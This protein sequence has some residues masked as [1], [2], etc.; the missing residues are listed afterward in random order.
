MTE[1][2]ISF[3][4]IARTLEPV[5]GGKDI[6]ITFQ[7]SRAIISA[8]VKPKRQLKSKGICHV[9]ANPALIK[10]EKEAFAMAMV[11]KYGKNINS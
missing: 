5:F 10:H 3:N 6:K 4:D 2:V 8:E 11:E 1:V 7:K 9:R